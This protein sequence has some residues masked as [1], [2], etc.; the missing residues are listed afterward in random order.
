[1]KRVRVRECV[2]LLMRVRVR[3]RVYFQ[4]VRHY[5]MGRLRLVGSLKL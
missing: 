5:G 1:M 4:H 2:R 3:E